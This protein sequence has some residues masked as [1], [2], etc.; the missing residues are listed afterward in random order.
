LK[1]KLFIKMT[2]HPVLV[3]QLVSRFAALIIGLE[4]HVNVVVPGGFVESAAVHK[5]LLL[6]PEASHSGNRH[7]HALEEAAGESVVDQKIGRLAPGNRPQSPS[8]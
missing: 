7:L 6:G 2:L 1:S 4:G 8:P 5:D 3:Q